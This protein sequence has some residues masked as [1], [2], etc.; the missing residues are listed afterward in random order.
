MYCLL[1]CKDIGNVIV[2]FLFVKNILLGVFLFNFKL[3]L[4]FFKFFFSESLRI[5]FLII[6]CFVEVLDGLN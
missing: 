4:G 1:V 6:R 2:R 3:F 5:N